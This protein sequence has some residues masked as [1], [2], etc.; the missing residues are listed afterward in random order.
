M[1]EWGQMAALAI[2]TPYARSQFLDPSP[3]SVATREAKKK[4]DA[5]A[6]AAANPADAAAGDDATKKDKAKNDDDDDDDELQLNVDAGELDPDHRLLLRSTLPLLQ[7]RSNA[8]VFGVIAL[9]VAVA[10]PL[11]LRVIGKALCRLVKGSREVQVIT[12]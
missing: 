12:S 5:A 7:S 2:L 6:A 9:Y 1:D 10:P 3:E 4:A 8:V 11:E